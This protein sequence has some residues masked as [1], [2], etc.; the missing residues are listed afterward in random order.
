[1]TIIVG[2]FDDPDAL[3]QTIERLADQG[4][5]ENVFD[6]STVPR[7]VGFHETLL[8]APGARSAHGDFGAPEKVTEANRLEAVRV[9]KDHLIKDFHLPSEVI[10]SYATSFYHEG[11]FVIV[12]TTARRAPEVMDIMRAGNASQ[13]NRHS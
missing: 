4:F 7:E 2:I 1:M 5:K 8:F 12:K 10:E 3:D 6:Q 11:K 13:V 9:F